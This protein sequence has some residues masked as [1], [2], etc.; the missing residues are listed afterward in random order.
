MN[1]GS[2]NYISWKQK[3]NA[4]V[5]IGVASVIYKKMLNDINEQYKVTQRVKELEK[6]EAALLIHK[7]Y[8]VAFQNLRYSNAKQQQHKN[9]INDQYEQKGQRIA[10]S[11]RSF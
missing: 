1:K 3:Q 6:T 2:K 9:N 10:K 4:L 5:Y 7:G 11:N 8:F